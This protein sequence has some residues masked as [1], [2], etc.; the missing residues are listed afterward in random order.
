[1]ARL[2][3]NVLSTLIGG[4]LFSCLKYLAYRF[5]LFFLVATSEEVVSVFSGLL[6]ALLRINRIFPPLSSDI[7]SILIQVSR[8]CRSRLAV[9][10]GTYPVFSAGQ[11]WPNL[12]LRSNSK[13]AILLNEINDAFR[14]TFSDYASMSA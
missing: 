2:A 3:I 12:Q 5:F 7:S 6:P 9:N 8:I 1:M 14:T 13:E 4:E 11:P 10:E